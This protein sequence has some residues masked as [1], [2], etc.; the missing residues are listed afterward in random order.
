MSWCAIKKSGCEGRG[1]GVDLFLT[2]DYVL[3]VAQDYALNDIRH[4]R[5]C[6]KIIISNILTIMIPFIPP[7]TFTDLFS[8]FKVRSARTT[9]KGIRDMLVEKFP[10]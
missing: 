8:Y 5:C 3:L 6:Q 1:S 10:Y 4:F 7:K 9:E 2:R